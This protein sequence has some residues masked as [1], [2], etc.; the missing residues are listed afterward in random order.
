MRPCTDS[1]LNA[2]VELFNACEEVDQT[3]I[4]ETVEQLQQ[5]LNSPSFNRAEDLR[6]WILE[7]E[8]SLL[9]NVSMC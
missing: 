7:G 6:L 3:G 2:I 9:W 1:D 4:W 8:G 5:D